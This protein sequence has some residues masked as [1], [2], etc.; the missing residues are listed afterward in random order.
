MVGL[1]NLNTELPYD[2]VILFLGIY[3]EVKTKTQ[4]DTWDTRVHGSII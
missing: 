4:M 2:P 1:K 3:T